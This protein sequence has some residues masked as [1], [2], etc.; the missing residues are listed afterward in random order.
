MALTLSKLMEEK[1]G[2]HSMWDSLTSLTS[3]CMSMNDSDKERCKDLT[4]QL[5]ELLMEHGRHLTEYVEDSATTD[6]EKMRDM[7]YGEFFINWGEYLIKINRDKVKV[8]PF[9][10]KIT[11][12]AKFVPIDYIRCWDKFER[13][14][15]ITYQ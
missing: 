15:D 1:V 5:G 7:K 12:P 11:N 13:Y 8:V 14:H 2:L 4:V 3:P 10:P 9:R 6:A